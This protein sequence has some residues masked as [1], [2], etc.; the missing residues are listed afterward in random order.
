MPLTRYE[1][2][3]EYSFA[4][5]DLYRAAAKDDP[6]GLLQGVAMAGL[7][8]IVRQLGDL[9]EF[10]A[11]V[12]HDLHE[13]VLA[14]AARSH[15]LLVR[16]QQLEIEVPYIEKLMFAQSNCA[17]FAYNPGLEWHGTIQNDQNHFTQGDLPRFIRNAYEDCRGP[18]RL[19]LLDKFDVAG[20][21]ACLKR[22]TDPS[23]FRME[24]ASS[25]LMKAEKEHQDRKAR[26]IKKARRYRNAEM[27]EAFFANHFQPRIHPVSLEAEDSARTSLHSHMPNAQ[28]SLVQDELN[29]GLE[30]PGQKIRFSKVSKDKLGSNSKTDVDL[31]PEVVEPKESSIE[32][33]AEPLHHELECKETFAGSPDLSPQPEQK[34]K[35]SHGAFNDVNPVEPRFDSEKT[36]ASASN[37]LEVQKKVLPLGTRISDDTT[38]F[39]SETDNYMDAMTTIDS[40]VETEMEVSMVSK[41]VVKSN[42]NTTIEKDTLDVQKVT[43][44]DLNYTRE[45]EHVIE[46]H[47]V[48]SPDTPGEWSPERTKPLHVSSPSLTE[49]HEALFANE[50]LTAQKSSVS[51]PAVG[52]DTSL[53]PLEDP[54]VGAGEL[55]DTESAEVI[56]ETPETPET[57]S[58]LQLETLSSAFDHLSESVVL[59]D[60]LS[61][62]TFT[63]NIS[64][65]SHL[66]G[67]TIAPPDKGLSLVYQKKDSSVDSDSERSDCIMESSPVSS[68][69]NSNIQPL[70]LLIESSRHCTIVIDSDDELEEMH[71]SSSSSPSLSSSIL[72]SPRPATLATTILDNTPLSL[73]SPMKSSLDSLSSFSHESFNNMPPHSTSPSPSEEVGASSSFKSHTDV[74]MASPIHSL[75]EESNHEVTSEGD[76]SFHTGADLA[77]SVCDQHLSMEETED[78]PPPPPLPPLEWRMTRR[79]GGNLSPSFEASESRSLFSQKPL[80]KHHSSFDSS[81][82]P[83][84]P[85]RIHTKHGEYMHTSQFPVCKG[86]FQETTM[87]SPKEELLRMKDVSTSLTDALMTKDS[88]GIHSPLNS[89]FT[90]IPSG[91]NEPIQITMSAK[92]SKVS[93][94]PTEFSSRTDSLNVIHLETN[95][96]TEALQSSRGSLKDDGEHDLTAFVIEKENTDVN[97]SNFS[98]K[99]NADSIDVKAPH[100]TPVMNYLKLPAANNIIPAPPKLDRLSDI[101]RPPLPPSRPMPLIPPKAEKNDA[102]IAAIASHDRSKLKKV[103]GWSQSSGT[104]GT[105]SR[106]LLFEQIRAGSFSLRRTKVEKEEQPRHIT[107]VNVAAILEKANAI[108]QAFAGSDDEDDDDDDWSDD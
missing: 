41:A 58:S 54:T 94:E 68:S 39:A 9:A 69:V 63:E 104:S 99:S 21:G 81:S 26:R 65:L 92:T 36:G 72:S 20:A 23:F 79:F 45:A 82:L 34:M 86:G 93:E 98:S 35:K 19:F 62:E 33:T 88:S 25:E 40:E 17:S 51:I 32:T 84:I 108:R 44:D 8:G 66:G 95:K 49:E 55:L 75:N 85:Q 70:K 91:S 77:G 103:S 28:H 14:T 53:P 10:A 6:E 105:D 5:P 100:E 11:E 57:C 74:H 90:A 97:H 96:T 50:I 1:I 89:D 78:L 7:V 46:D 27:R 48:S 18:P 107:N 83:P 31:Q 2:R 42:S 13:D 3:N 37:N 24:W 47:V 30:G 56:P 87:H 4:N 15:E 43:H 64:S 102:L 12:F 76:L 38:D 67:K 71:V 60:G 22:Y 101:S 61:Q 106:E 73:L 80:R 29:A 52:N 16:M 59:L